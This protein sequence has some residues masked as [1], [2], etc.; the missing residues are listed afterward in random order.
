MNVFM[1]IDNNEFIDK[2]IKDNI[3]Y[4]IVALVRITKYFAYNI[5]FRG[6]F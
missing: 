2:Y 4:C 1:K 5:I 3:N 6:V